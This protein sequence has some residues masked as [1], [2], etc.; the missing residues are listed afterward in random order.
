MPRDAI[1]VA[2]TLALSWK[3]FKKSKDS[4]INTKIINR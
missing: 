1:A 2:T 4:A 3:P